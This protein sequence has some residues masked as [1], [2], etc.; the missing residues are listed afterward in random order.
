MPAKLF[1]GY[2]NICRLSRLHLNNGTCSPTNPVRRVL[3]FCNTATAIIAY[4]AKAENAK[5]STRQPNFK[6]WLDGTRV[7]RLT[8]GRQCRSFCLFV[9]VKSHRLTHGSAPN[10]KKRKFLRFSNGVESYA[11]LRFHCRNAPNAG[12]QLGNFRAKFFRGHIKRHVN[13]NHK[14]AVQNA[15]IPHRNKIIWA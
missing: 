10:K 11:L 13:H 15:H 2:G 14:C 12:N 3:L 4:I 9:C 1:F 5:K 6:R 8:A 7:C